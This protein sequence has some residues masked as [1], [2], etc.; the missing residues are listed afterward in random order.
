MVVGRISFMNVDS[1]LNNHI[2]TDKGVGFLNVSA[3]TFTDVS[4][5]TD[6]NRT[7]KS[8]IV[9]GK[10]YDRFI[11]MIVDKGKIFLD[12]NTRKDNDYCIEFMAEVGKPA[13]AYKN[14]TDDSCLLQKFDIHASVGKMYIITHGNE[15]TKHTIINVKPSIVIT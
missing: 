3:S 2:V 6:L 14:S 7:V 5:I 8:F 13:Y 11:N 1:L 9:D 12:L 15:D 4:N 10:S